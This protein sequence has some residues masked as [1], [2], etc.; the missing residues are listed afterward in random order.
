MIKE[1]NET[2]KRFHNGGALLIEGIELPMAHLGEEEMSVF[3][4]I[5]SEL[6]NSRTLIGQ[7]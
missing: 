7:S 5:L 4:K 6:S 3:D 1:C 2:L